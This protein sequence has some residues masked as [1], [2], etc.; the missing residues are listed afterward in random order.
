MNVFYVA[1]ERRVRDSKNKDRHI[2]TDS[3]RMQCFVYRDGYAK[4]KYHLGSSIS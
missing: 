1:M 4:Q 3:E 2:L